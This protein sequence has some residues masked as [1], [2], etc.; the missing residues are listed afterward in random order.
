MTRSW[1]AAA[2][3][4]SA[5]PACTE[6]LPP[7]GQLLVTILTDAPLPAPAGAPTTGPLP[8]F[9]RLRL[10]LVPPG[11]TEACEGCRREFGVDHALVALGNASFGVLTPEGEEGWRLVV[12]LFRSGGTTSG[13][14]RPA[15]T[16]ESVIAL[17]ANQAEGKQ[18]VS[19]VL[20]TDDLATPVGSLDAPVAPIEGQLSGL[21]GTWEGARQRSCEVTPRDGE[22]C[23]PGGAFWMGDP[24][25]ELDAAFDLAGGAERLVVLS[26]FY[27]DR[28]EVPVSAFRASGLAESIVPGG[29]SNNPHAPDASFPACTYTTEPGPFEDYPTACLSWT[30]AEAY[31]NALGGQL[32]TEAQLEYVSSAFGAHTFVW[33][34]DPPRCEDVVFERGEAIAP[35][36]GLGL[37]IAPPGSGLR[38][39]LTIDGLEVVDLAGNVKEWA[40]D[41]W[42]REGE[43]C[44]PSGVLRD[45][46]CDTPSELDFN[47]R[48]VRG[49]DWDSDELPMR[50]AVRTRIQNETSAVSSRVGFRC[51]RAATPAP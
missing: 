3:L 7:D 8:L 35:C 17:P 42:N 4:A 31:C 22:V 20:W 38:D 21:V 39:R 10:D 50:A 14:P 13:A 1:L 49:G 36:G 30:K 12:R 25:L 2:L 32:P 5:L 18:A 37:G 26:P 47:T 19:V 28:Q 24:R 11:A 41:R 34:E 46:F 23:V 33:G 6:A 15:S 43:S 9:D 48:S 40:R 51:A 16:L 29:P 45:P 27:L 44:W